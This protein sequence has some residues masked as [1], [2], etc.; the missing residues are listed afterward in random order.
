[1]IVYVDMDDV[2]CDYSTAH[3]S[4]LER[5]PEIAFP[6]S[7]YGF[8][9]NLEPVAGAID[10]LNTMLSR[11]NYSPY[12]LT[13]PSVRNPWSYT[14]KRMWVEKHLD[15]QYIERLIISSDKSLLNGS[16]LIDDNIRG[17]GQDRFLGSLIQF[18]GE[19]Y[20]DWAAVRNYLKI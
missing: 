16:F 19:K 4:A 9:Q 7:Q 3:R 17:K 2:I 6:Q 12:I 1:M 13:A 20:P 5:C 10:A 14:E 8:F 11:S 15:N 18:G